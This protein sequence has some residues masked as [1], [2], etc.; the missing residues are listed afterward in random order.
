[1]I[2]EVVVGVVIVAAVT[3]VVLEAVTVAAAV[4]AAVGDTGIFDF[5]LLV[6]IVVFRVESDR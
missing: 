2:V 6:S 3:V 5:N 4:M 1:V